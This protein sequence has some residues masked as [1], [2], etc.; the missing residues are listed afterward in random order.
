QITRADQGTQGAHALRD[1]RDSLLAQLSQYLEVSTVEQPSGSVD[2]YVGSLPVILD[3]VNRGLKVRRQTVNGDLQVDA[4]LASDGSVLQPTS[5]K[6][7]ALVAARK[8]DVDQAVS[9]L[10]DFANNLIYEV[11]K[12][13]SQGQGLVGFDSV[14][15]TT[16]VSDPT[17]ALNDPAAGIPFL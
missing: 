15:G 7:G 10:D 1:Q 13:H 16:S 4:T 6:L 3:G 5:G 17:A 8:N 12:V 11:N 9:T 2:V 14:T